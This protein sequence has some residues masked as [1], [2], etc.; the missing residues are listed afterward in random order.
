MSST[1]TVT[2]TAIVSPVTIKH[3]AMS[4]VESSP[5][6]KTDLS[7]K[8][9]RA[10]RIITKKDPPINFDNYNSH[11][12][13]LALFRAMKDIKNQPEK[14]SYA[15]FKDDDHTLAQ[16]I[17]RNRLHGE[18]NSASGKSSDKVPNESSTSPR[19]IK[20]EYDPSHDLPPTP[21]ICGWGLNF[22]RICVDLE[23]GVPSS[24][25]VD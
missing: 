3:E 17:K 20:K 4:P 1:E 13:A 23:V 2:T 8:P 14:A 12:I 10:S 21:V 22:F 6:V 11:G 16:G 15:N 19:E 7:L 5:T 25:F 9:T 18:D 24:R